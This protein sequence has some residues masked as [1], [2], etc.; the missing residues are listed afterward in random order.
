MGDWVDLLKPGMELICYSDNRTY[1][2]SSIR[3]SALFTT[4]MLISCTLSGSDQ[5]F[6]RRDIMSGFKPKSKAFTLLH[7]RGSEATDHDS[8]NGS[9]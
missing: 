5:K 4:A 9:D 3:I 7:Y 2:I 1:T 6:N 8:A